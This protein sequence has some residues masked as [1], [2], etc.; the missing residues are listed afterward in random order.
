[1]TTSDVQPI[2]PMSEHDCW[3]RLSSRT[4]GRLVT[5]VDGQPDIFPVNYVVQR[6]TILIRTAE[7][8]KLAS[9]AINSRVAFEADD[10]DVTHGWS[11]VV[12]GNARVLSSADELVAAERAQVMP[13]TATRKLRFIRIEPV[14]ITG[15]WFQFGGESDQVCD[16]P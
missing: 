8:T 7:G 12:K 2:T 14:E 10:H 11:V 6:H 4:L 1:M 9:A 3:A 5:S 16:L 13:W 15:R